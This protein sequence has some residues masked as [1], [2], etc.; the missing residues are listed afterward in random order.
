MN[1]HILS[2]LDILYAMRKAKE[3][4]SLPRSTKSIGLKFTGKSLYNADAAD[5]CLR[6]FRE[7]GF[8]LEGT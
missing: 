2:I 8:K 1:S 7:K 4:A 6:L 3:C 5:A